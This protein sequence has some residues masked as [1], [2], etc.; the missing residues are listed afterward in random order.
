[1]TNQAITIDAVTKRYGSQVALEDVSMNV[2]PGETLALL[3]HNGA[4]KTT[5]IKLILGLTRPQSGAIS[6][7]DEIPGSEAMRRQCAYLPE[8]VAFHKS[9]TGREQLTLFSRLKG[10][11][12]SRI[13]GHLERVGLGEAMDRRIGTYSK[14]MR[15]RLG[16]A[17]MLIGTPRI[18]VLDEPT[19]G[20]DPLSRDMFYDMV[21]ELAGAGAAVL[22]SSHALTELEA[23]TDRI[24]ILR[25]GRVAAD[26]RLSQLRAGA[27]LPIRV[28]V[29]AEAEA[30]AEV[31]RRFG[32]TRINGRSV[33]LVCQADEKIQRISEVTALEPAVE[34]IDIVPPSLE[35]V[36]RHYS[37]PAAAQEDER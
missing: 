11:S 6:V 9:L 23:R 34:D 15:Q 21:S 7:L 35:D 13:A 17:Q 36:Y 29:E 27:R 24:V 32:G 16:L 18:A 5:L 10:G 2:A 20:L 22:L 14:G 26:G 4:G 25:Q 19:S 8:N 28:R 3:G 12:A 33:E 1:M 30:A 37:R 31:A